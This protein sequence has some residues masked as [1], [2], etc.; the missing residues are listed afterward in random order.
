MSILVGP[1]VYI[2]MSWIPSLSHPLGRD[3]RS[4]RSSMELMHSQ[5]KLD[6]VWMGLGAAG[7]KRFI[8]T[9]RDDRW[10]KFLN[11]F[12]LSGDRRSV[13]GRRWCFLNLRVALSWHPAV[14]ELGDI[15]MWRKYNR[16]GSFK[17]QGFGR[18]EK[19]NYKQEGFGG[20]MGNSQ[21]KRP[22]LWSVCAY[23]CFSSATFGEVWCLKIR[24]RENKRRIQRGRK[25]KRVMLLSITDRKG[26]VIN[27][28]T[29]NSSIYTQ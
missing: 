25:A 2:K 19:K 9:R 22:P 26:Y 13:S 17:T 11:F 28:K 10:I 6:C 3:W 15:L 1:S 18:G 27:T 8:I 14:A 7:R 21:T 24:V 23:V 16:P 20:F 29:P 5:A 12:C 4:A